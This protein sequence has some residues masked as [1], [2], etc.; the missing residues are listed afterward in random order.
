MLIEPKTSGSNKQ[1]K[2][3]MSTNPKL[4]NYQSKPDDEFFSSSSTLIRNGDYV[5]G[6]GNWQKVELNTKK[7]YPPHISISGSSLL[8]DKEATP[9]DEDKY[10]SS[11]SSWNNNDQIMNKIRSA[12]KR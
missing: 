7:L 11:G 10:V 8:S 4:G 12:K 1:M 6:K 5:F 9:L 2:K 3:Q